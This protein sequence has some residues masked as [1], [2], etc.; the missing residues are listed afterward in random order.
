MAAVTIYR[1][2]FLHQ[3]ARAFTCVTWSVPRGAPK[4]SSVWNWLRTRTSITLHLFPVKVSVLLTADGAKAYKNRTAERNTWRRDRVEKLII[5]QLAKK[6]LV[7]LV[8][9][10]ISF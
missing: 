5:A 1:H 10:Q 3:V 9:T 4:L 7:L 6:Y 8:L 2:R